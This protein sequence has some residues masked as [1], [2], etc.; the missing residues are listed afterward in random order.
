MTTST[1][2]TMRQIF[3]TFSIVTFLIVAQSCSRPV[4]YKTAE[5]DMAEVRLTLN[6]NK[7]LDFYFKSFD[8]PDTLD[9]KDDRVT[10]FKSSGTWRTI[11]DDIELTFKK[12]KEDFN[13]RT[14]FESEK[15][16]TVTVNDTTFKFNKDRETITLWG[17]ESRKN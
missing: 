7:T 14:I 2:K 5:N 11:G 12:S 16:T 13:Y 4:T 17:T 3:L 10:I 8:E 15:N 1:Y 6:P 9:P